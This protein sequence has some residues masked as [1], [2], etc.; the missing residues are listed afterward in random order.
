[1]Q[2]QSTDNKQMNPIW[3]GDWPGEGGAEEEAIAGARKEKGGI[4]W[5][6]ETVREATERM[7]GW[8]GGGRGHERAA[9]RGG[10]GGTEAYSKP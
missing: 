8:M 2:V 9:A 3:K 1:M 10:D 7:D 4:R 5:K 6:A